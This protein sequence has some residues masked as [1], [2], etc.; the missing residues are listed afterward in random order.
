MSDMILDLD[1]PCIYA[2]N[3][4]DGNGYVRKTVN[5]KRMLAHRRAYEDAYGP[6]PEG[7][8]VDHE[9][10]NADPT[11]VRGAKCKHRACINPK[12]LWAKPSDINTLAGRGPAAVNFQ[13]THCSRNHVYNE[14][15]TYY[16]PNSNKR[17][18]RMCKFLWHQEMLRK[19]K[20][21][22][23][24]QPYDTVGLAITL[25]VEEES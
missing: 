23:Y 24:N 17:Q 2:T 16:F 25:E 4:P 3:Q 18:C 7:W 15:N 1:S 21:I 19:K 12:H 9:C 6:I 10:H 5:G 22:E 11:C 13:K 8:N 20:L 14:E